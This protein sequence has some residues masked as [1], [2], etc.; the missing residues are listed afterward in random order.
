MMKRVIWIIICLFVMLMLCDAAA[1]G[2]INPWFGLI[3]AWV[4]FR[5][6]FEVISEMC[7][8]KSDVGECIRH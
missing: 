8:E 7:S 5:E 3:A 2:R 1:C 4:F 6:A